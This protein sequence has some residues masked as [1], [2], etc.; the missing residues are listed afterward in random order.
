MSVV[1]LLTFDSV[2][3]VT[4]ISGA[5][6]K[7]CL[8]G[9]ALSGNPTRT[10]FGSGVYETRSFDPY[11]NWI[12]PIGVRDVTRRLVLTY[13]TASHIFAQGPGA[14]ALPSAWQQKN[15]AREG[16]VRLLS[17]SLFVL[18]VQSVFFAVT[19]PQCVD[20]DCGGDQGIDQ[21]H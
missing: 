21:R 2:T 5:Y 11:R 7:F 1:F 4:Y 20:A 17:R 13:N 9:N 19:P 10:G 16:P 12:D 6:L 8:F 15:R 14:Y 3:R 18:V